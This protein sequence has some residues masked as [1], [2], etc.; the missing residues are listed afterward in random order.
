MPFRPPESSGIAWTLWEPVAFDDTNSVAGNA[1][2]PGRKASSATGAGAASAPLNTAAVV[3]AMRQEGYQVGFEAG[4]IDGLQAGREAS[5]AEVRQTTA[6]LAQAISRLD[7]GVAD[8]E[9]AV[10]DELLALAI[11]IARKVINQAIIVK[12]QAILETIREAL[13]HVPSQHT[14]IH[15]NAEDA[16]L[17]RTHAGEQLGRAGHRI[18]EDPQLERGD[19]VIEAGGAHLDCRLATRWQRVIGTLDKDAPWLVADETEQA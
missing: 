9:H 2:A 15:L 16:A 10:A 11:E 1:K 14:V 18:H 5:E 19:V 3:E 12:P 7:F 8:L 6:H 13:A 4:R 17:V